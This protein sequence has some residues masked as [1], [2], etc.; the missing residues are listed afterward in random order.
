MAGII[1]PNFE[2]EEFDK[3]I[4]ILSKHLDKPDVRDSVMITAFR[5]YPVVK[6]LV[7]MS[8]DALVFAIRLVNWSLDYGEVETNVLAIDRVFAG[9]SLRLNNEEKAELEKIISNG[10]ERAKDKGVIDQEVNQQITPVP[11]ISQSG[12]FSL[13]KGNHP[14][15]AEVKD[16]N[17]SSTEVSLEE[18]IPTKE[19]YLKEIFKEITELLEV[20]SAQPVRRAIVKHIDKEYR[21]IIDES[22]HEK[23]AKFIADF[24]ER[25]EESRQEKSSNVYKT[26]KF[27]AQVIQRFNF[28][29]EFFN[30]PQNAIKVQERTRDLFYNL[31]SCIVRITVADSYISQYK[32]GSSST[33]LKLAVAT[34]AGVEVCIAKFAGRGVAFSPSTDKTDPKDFGGQGGFSVNID[35]VSSGNAEEAVWKILVDLYKKAIP[36]GKI[37]NKASLNPKELNYLSSIIK[38]KKG[39]KSIHHYVMSELSV[40][41]EEAFNEISQALCSKDK[42][43]ELVVVGFGK[44]ENEIFLFNE[45]DFA[46]SIREYL[47]VLEQT[48]P[49][50]G[51][52]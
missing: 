6:N 5:T 40:D 29:D 44:E 46:T 19:D 1:V 43:P 50:K 16:N 34:K 48:F 45:Y 51:E 37:E 21:E 11:V 26:I 3:I 38:V 13:E 41:N 24:H 23:I 42:V 14:D 18:K 22:K 39:F 35:R 36:G 27:L 31:L 8:G 25:D 15:S 28:S 7:E 2:S 52:Q 49:S 4:A 9:V 10:R 30:A 12:D 20:Q 17:T 33:V 32:Q 47:L